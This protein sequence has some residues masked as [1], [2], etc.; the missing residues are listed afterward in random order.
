M[1]RSDIIRTLQVQFKRMRPNDA[2]AILDS[3]SDQ[4]IESV[5]A[6]DRIEIRGFGTFQP[7]SRATK[8]GYNPCTGKPM[9]LEAGRTILFKPSRELIKR[10]N[11]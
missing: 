7:R 9:H 2:A 4:L 10:M 1:K 8:L 5:S 3:V 11:G 6:G